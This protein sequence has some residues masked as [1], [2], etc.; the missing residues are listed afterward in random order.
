MATLT[1]SVLTLSEQI[2]QIGPKGTLLEVI[3]VMS[4]VNELDI[5]APYLMANDRFTDVS[6]KVIQLPAVGTRRINRGSAG[7]VGRT[8]Q[9]REFIE[10][11]EARPYVDT[12]LLESE[13]DGGKQARLNQIKMFVE[14]MAQAKAEH[15]IYGNNAEDDEVIDGLATRYKA[16]SHAS[17]YGVGGT[18]TD[19]TSM[20][21][22]EWDP[23]RCCF[24]YPKA[25]PNGGKTQALG[26]SDY[27]NGR[28]RIT[29]DEGRAFDAMENVIRVAFGL[30]I[31]DDRNV[32]RL[33]NIESSGTDNN[34]L[35][36]GKINLLV[37]ALNKLTSKGRKAVIYANADVKT[38]FDIWAM[39]KLNGCWLVEQ[40]SGD[41]MTVFK[42]HP[43][44]MVEAIKSNET[45]IS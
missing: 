43:I 6:S 29:D 11:L 23:A 18:G 8:A 32:A 24:I 33:A 37:E 39:D 35:A 45:A 10:I 15:I 13:Q 4:Q 41:P 12:L 1:Q 42:G 38:Q 19:V 31:L 22:M 36:T 26:V 44:R 9:H 14:A 2:K 16:L 34:L 27:D 30:K 25:V 21:V 5:D 17:V 20:W 28:V 40:T 3:N 7:G